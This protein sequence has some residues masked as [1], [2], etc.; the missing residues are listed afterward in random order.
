MSVGAFAS[1]RMLALLRPVL[2]PAWVALALS[3]PGSLAAQGVD[4]AWRQADLQ[5]Q[6]RSF[7]T[8]RS[9]LD[10]SGTAFEAAR[11][12]GDVNAQL[13]TLLDA[14]AASIWLPAPEADQVLSRIP[15]VVARVDAQQA[16]QRSQL[17]D[18]LAFQALN[19][20]A[21]G[22]LDE[23]EAV[24]ARAEEASHPPD[25][26]G[27]RAHIEVAKALLT[28]LR[29]DADGALGHLAKA[30]EVAVHDYTRALIRSWQAAIS[31]RASFFDDGLLRAS[32]RL[33][34]DANRLA[35]PDS[36]LALGAFN[37]SVLAQCEAL[38]GEPDE[39]DRRGR[40]FSRLTARLLD[41]QRVDYGDMGMVRVLAAFRRQDIALAERLGRRRVLM[42]WGLAA[43]GILA[44]IVV[45][46]GV[47]QARQ[48]GRLRALSGQLSARNTQLQLMSQ[49]HTRLLAASC[50]DLRE[51]AHALC[52][53]AEMAEA[54]YQPD[55]PG[56]GHD[57]DHHLASIRHCSMTLTDM[58]SELLD[59][60]RIEGGHYVPERR[61]VSLHA[62]FDDLQLQFQE[63]ARRKG[64]KLE[65]ADSDLY[66]RTDAYLLRRMLF[67]LVGN[68]LRTTEAGDVRVSAVRDRHGS[69]QLRVQDSNLS[70]SPEALSALLDRGPQPGPISNE[71]SGVGVSI[72]K[73]A[74]DLL[75]VP[76]TVT[77]QSGRGNLVTLSLE[78]ASPTPL[79]AEPATAPAGTAL[80]QPLIA[81]M[82]DDAESR[83]GMASLLTHWGYHVVTAASA[84]ELWAALQAQSAGPP[85][86]LL[87]DLNLG[88][89]NGLDEAAIVRAWPG[90]AEMPVMLLTGDQDA[91]ASRRA[92]AAGIEVGYKPLLPRQL[93]AQVQAATQ[94]K[95]AGGAPQALRAPV[96][97]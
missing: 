50:H 87:T 12:R 54:S 71:G 60:T 59:L 74:A 89:L 80:R 31:R 85:D 47:M 25:D 27:H 17:V 69:V 42:S 46:A 30:Y 75:E 7:S 36:A 39:A 18:L 67:S 57:T 77:S 97:A 64:L 44:G 5:R 76:L 55:A 22:R 8:P 38:L 33:A 26:P 19:L 51:P 72:V 16:T 66:V 3:V 32:R 63:T 9:L 24:L 10:A 56:Q 65:V 29:D 15:A 52:I 28:L 35:P 81:V 40:E 70:L 48:K 37:L 61:T 53:L 34:K 20:V 41:D 92:A 82:E 83:Q 94:R 49:S 96:P 6:Q 11:R 95:P 58:L 23:A 93:L 43:A 45:A 13:T 88:A 2:Q 90:C 86:L 1:R 62:L 21:A 68:A 14:A 79:P 84:Q 91:A 73:R 78:P 4:F